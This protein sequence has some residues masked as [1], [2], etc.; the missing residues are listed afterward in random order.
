MDELACGINVSNT[1]IVRHLFPLVRT[2]VG[3]HTAFSPTVD[4]AHTIAVQRQAVQ[5]RVLL[6]V[7][8]CQKIPNHWGNAKE[9]D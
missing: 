7:V 4:N 1:E 9:L 8:T 5:E 2:M 3:A 6:T